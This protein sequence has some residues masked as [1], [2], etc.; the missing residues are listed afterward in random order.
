VLYG[1]QKCGYSE[2]MSIS[3]A[4]RVLDVEKY[5]ITLH[6]I[7]L[8]F[9]VLYCEMP[10][11][12]FLAFF[13]LAR[14]MNSLKKKRLYEVNLIASSDVIFSVIQVLYSVMKADF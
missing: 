9:I 7:Y 5:C 14:A 8:L 2:V 10:P 11:V 3:A 13:C 1:S 4:S 12:S 6:I